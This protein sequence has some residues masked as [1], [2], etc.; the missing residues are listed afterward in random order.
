MA[1]KHKTKQET[2]L[3]QY[4]ACNTTT[5][6]ETR[7]SGDSTTLDLD[8]DIKVHSEAIFAP[9]RLVVSFGNLIVR[10]FPKQMLHH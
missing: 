3:V 10:S 8:W 4:C 7:R 6:I 1:F 2:Y 5:V 9:G